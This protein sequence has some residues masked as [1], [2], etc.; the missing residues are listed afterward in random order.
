MWSVDQYAPT[1]FMPKP[2]YSRSQRVNSSSREDS[3]YRGHMKTP[4][5]DSFYQNKFIVI[6][7]ESRKKPHTHN[8][9]DSISKY[10]MS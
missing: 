5:V 10:S 2:L 8:R 3:A 9:P 6:L 4:E 1:P 7:A